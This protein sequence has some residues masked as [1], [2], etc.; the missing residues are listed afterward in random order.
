M[1][2]VILYKVFMTYNSRQIEQL[3]VNLITD[4]IS[5]SNR[6]SPYIAI[7]DREPEWDGFIYLQ[8]LNQKVTG[9]VAVQVKGKTVK[10]VPQKPTYPVSIYSL[11]NYK[12]DGGI[13]YFVVYLLD[14]ERYPYY[15]KLAP[16]DLK[17]YIHDAK[18]HS[19]TNIHLKALPQDIKELEAEIQDFYVD[20]KRQTSFAYSPILTLDNAIKRNYKIKFNVS[21]FSDKDSLFN[22]LYKKSLYLYAE[23]ANET[24]NVDYPI[25]DG[26]Y[27][28]FIGK[29]INEDISINNIVYFN[30]C[31]C[32]KEDDFIIFL[33]GNC[34]RITL[35]TEES[36][37]K[38][39]KLKFESE[40]QLLSERINQLKFLKNLI[41]FKQFNIGNVEM[42]IKAENIKGYSELVSEI[43]HLEKIQMLFGSL[44]ITTDEFNLG[45]LSEEDWGKIE[46]LAKAIVDKKAVGQKHE[47]NAI[48]SAEIANY[49]FMLFAQKEDN[50][51]Y[52]IYNFF[53][54]EKEILFAYDDGG[55]KLATSMFT[56]VFCKSD[57]TTY[58]NMDYSKLL[59]SYEGAAKYNPY[60]TDRANND[61]LMALKGYDQM[62][63]KD[64]RLYQ[65]ILSLCDWIIKYSPDKLPIHIINKYQ[66]VKRKRELTKEE[67]KELCMLLSEVPN[68][69]DVQTAIHL[70]LDNK[71]QAELYFDS[72]NESEKKFFKS[73]PIYF[74]MNK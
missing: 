57:F 13:I 36:K 12:R 6:M 11:Q 37:E 26:S 44:G 24:G 10:R 31:N 65:A 14:G 22:N 73:L 43:E 34:V 18:G 54:S 2:K 61:M 45:N 15:A 70:L 39:G 51:K 1:D 9:R 30:H 68:D 71:T 27:K 58:N 67:K 60:I 33:I 29:A 4:I 5:R 16:L 69:N 17:K 72:M 52:R 41:E 21:G 28:I 49:K 64:D 47:L 50:G 3:S 53:D 74:F 38:T 42:P 59:P 62:D 66:V 35:P 25:G 23:I 46:L 7:G 56:F 63:K 48:T 55:K 19:T 40:S 32:Y 8:S 20:C